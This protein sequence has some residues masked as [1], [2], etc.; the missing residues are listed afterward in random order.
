MSEETKVEQNPVEK[1][2]VPKKFNAKKLGIIG[3]VAVVLIALI[4]GI[5]IY[6]KPA[7]RLT[8]QLDLGNRYLEEQNYEQ[9]IV[10]FDKSIA[11]DSMCVDAYLG[12]AQAYE[13]MGDLQSALET[14]QTGYDLT[15]DERL[16]V[17]LDA[18]E[19]QIMQIRQAA[20]AAR[21][22]E[23]EAA[24]LAA[25][26]AEPDVEEEEQ[27]GTYIELPFSLAD[28][29][30]MGYDF[31]ESHLDEIMTDAGCILPDDKIPEPDKYGHYP[32]QWREGKW[33]RTQFKTT[34]DYVSLMF[35]YI[36][37]KKSY[38]IDYY[39][40]E[41]DTDYEYWSFGVD[42]EFDKDSWFE[43]NCNAPAV[44][45]DTYEEWCKEMGIDIIK[46]STEGIAQSEY[47]MQYGTFDSED[48]EH[49]IYYRDDTGIYRVMCEEAVNSDHYVSFTLRLR[50]I[51]SNVTYEIRAGLEDGVVDYVQYFKNKY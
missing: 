44:P 10:E 35:G 42:N 39:V 37:E 4:I 24:R 41:F 36:P 21:Q 27:P 7:N 31:L 16:K 49:E 30:V 22:A 13:G 46:N 20:E 50:E 47:T 18:L 29:R 9:A 23:E 1:P 48:P 25:E 26:E 14:L 51:N 2:D 33:G 17:K 32:Y 19:A 3:A 12:K 6:N 5:G 11:I 34:D 45:G 28:I 40:F 43:Y 38:L 15:G 8:R